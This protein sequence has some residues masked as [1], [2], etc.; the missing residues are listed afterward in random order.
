MAFEQAL[1]TFSYLDMGAYSPDDRCFYPDA[2]GLGPISD[3][4]N[5]L[6]NAYRLVISGTEGEHEWTTFV[7]AGRAAARRYG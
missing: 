6:Q 3:R 2:L 7:V 1:H 5:K 4:V